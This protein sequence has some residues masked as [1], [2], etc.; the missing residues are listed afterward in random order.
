MGTDGNNHDF[1]NDIGLAMG[2]AFTILGTKQI[3]DKRDGSIIQLV[4][5]RN[6][7]G[8]ERYHGDYSDNSDK[9]TDDLRK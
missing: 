8:M 9:W 6:P 2:H 3:T 1:T 4:K 7:W 5:I